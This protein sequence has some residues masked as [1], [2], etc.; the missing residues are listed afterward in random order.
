MI[1]SKIDSFLN[2][3]LVQF[4]IDHDLILSWIRCA[5]KFCDTF[6]LWISSFLNISKEWFKLFGFIT[7]FQLSLICEKSK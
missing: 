1:V 6:D 7:K 2:C 5:L 3:W 4:L